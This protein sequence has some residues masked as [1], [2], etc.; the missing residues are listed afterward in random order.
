MTVSVNADRELFGRLLVAAKNRDINLKEVLSYELCSVPISLAHP[1]GSLR[2]T[3]KSALMH[4]LEKDVTCRSS[5]PTS[6]LPTA[7]L[8]DAMALIQMVKSSGSATFGELSQK[9]EDIVAITLRQNI[10][11]RV[12]LIFDQYRS[13]SIKAGERSRRGESSSLE[14]NIHNGSTPVPKQWKKFI[15]NPKN[16]ENLAEFLCK[17]FSEHLPARLGPMQKVIVAGRFRDGS[18]V[19]FLA[20]GCVAVEPNLR[21]DHEEAESCFTP[22]MLQPPIHGL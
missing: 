6:Q 22:N 3:T 1:D 7:F 9:Y 19:V 8:I 20:R 11:T 17:S 5:L 2:K 21:S 16:K 15:S 10:C 4:L 14:V 12:D 18:K 13:V